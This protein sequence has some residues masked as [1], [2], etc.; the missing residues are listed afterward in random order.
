ME[1]VVNKYFL[2][3]KHTRA[4]AHTHNACN[5]KGQCKLLPNQFTTFT[6]SN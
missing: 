3:K 1:H 6:N 5:K 2:K 4:R